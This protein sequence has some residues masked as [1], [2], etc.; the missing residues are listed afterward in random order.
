MNSRSCAILGPEPS[1]FP[2]GYDEEDE[3]SGALKLILLN[4]VNYWLVED[5]KSFIV[6]L[7]AGIGLYAAE[8]IG[9]LREKNPDISLKCIVPWEEQATK[10]TPDLRERYY[11]A[12]ALCSEVETVSSEYTTSCEVG[13]KL[14]AIDLA[15]LVFAVSAREEDPF[16]E[17]ELHYARRTNKN[18]LVFYSEKSDFHN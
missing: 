10:W 7:D 6:A 17:I 16:L 11:N 4:M 15:D 13:S 18:V 1:R 9:G 14:R 12:Q 2:W 8:L 5:I 3:R